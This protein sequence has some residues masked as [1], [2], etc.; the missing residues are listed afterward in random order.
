[1]PRTRPSAEQIAEVLRRQ[2]HDADK[3]AIQWYEAVTA[4]RV[5]FRTT[6]AFAEAWLRHAA[7]NNPLVIA[8]TTASESGFLHGCVQPNNDR[9]PTLGPH[10]RG[11]WHE[12][13]YEIAQYT[14]AYI[15]STGYWIGEAKR[16]KGGERLPRSESSFIVL[17]EAVKHIFG[18][19][20]RESAEQAVVRQAERT[21][22]ESVIDREHGDAIRYISALLVESGLDKRRMQRALGAS[23]V[24]VGGNEVALNIHLY[25]SEID[26]LADVIKRLGIT[27]GD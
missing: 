22:E 1:M 23:V 11:G 15:N 4:V 2:V 14:A 24:S 13:G 19:A 7:E 3:R 17:P 27:P 18:E 12:A 26:R 10:V 16:R 6:K 9:W 20:E 25:D 21:V 8:W 5:G